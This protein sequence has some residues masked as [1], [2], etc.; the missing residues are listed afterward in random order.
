MTKCTELSPDRPSATLELFCA[1]E[2][3]VGT[4]IR[5]TV[6]FASST[7]TIPVVNSFAVAYSCFVVEEK[8]KLRNCGLCPRAR[9]VRC[10]LQVAADAAT[11][12]S[13]KLMQR[14]I[15]TWRVVIGKHQYV[16]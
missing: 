16:G 2:V 10:K 1:D 4:A 9:R 11:T 12:R 3:N 13:A 7:T 15:L 8:R 5:E 14:E 6:M